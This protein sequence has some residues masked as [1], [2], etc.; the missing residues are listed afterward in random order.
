MGWSEIETD[1]FTISAILLVVIVA[2]GIIGYNYWG[3]ETPDPTPKDLIEVTPPKNKEL[4]V[5]V[6]SLD[7]LTTKKEDPNKELL[8]KLE[9]LEAK[10][11]KKVEE[12]VEDYVLSDK[13]V[14]SLLP[15]ANDLI[16]SHDCWNL[17][18]EGR[19]EARKTFLAE[20]GKNIKLSYVKNKEFMG[21][22]EYELQQVGKPLDVQI[23][24]VEVDLD[25]E[26]VKCDAN[27]TWYY[28]WESLY[29]EQEDKM[30]IV[31]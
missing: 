9:A 13:V 16:K 20:V 4:L 12:K 29:G 19:L 1:A 10:L 23:L 3:T 6:E 18:W 22:V 30:V 24:N 21:V 11:D 26:E 27:Q 31:N 17:D 5:E 25:T 8:E 15:K 7:N 14:D 2:G 28:D